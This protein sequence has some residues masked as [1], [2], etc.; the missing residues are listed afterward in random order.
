MS[1]TNDSQKII[2]CPH[3]GKAI[4]ATSE[5]CPYCQQEITMIMTMIT[6]TMKT[7]I[8]I[9]VT[10]VTPATVATQAVHQ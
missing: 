4:S 5:K 9:T 2:D 10:A 1:D 7:M 3:C 8:M 6:I